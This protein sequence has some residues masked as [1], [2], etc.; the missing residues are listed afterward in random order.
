VKKERMPNTPNLGQITRIIG[1]V[2]DIEFKDHLPDIYNALKL[3]R[4]D[5]NTL[6]LEVELQLSQT[7]VRA[8]ALGSTDGLSRELEVRDTG[9]PISVPVGEET[10]GRV[11]NVVGELIDEGEQSTFA[12]T[13]PIH[14]QAPKLNAL[15]T[16]AEMLETGIKVI[17][18]IAPFVKGGKVGAFGGAGVGKTVIIQEL[19][20]RSL[21]LCGRW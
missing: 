20:R 21:R 6:T 12:H 19:I 1:P 7:E 14:H 15:S 5:G 11:F 3:T 13:A 2:V 8:I 17:D 9:A 18:L 4:P 10:L 16:K